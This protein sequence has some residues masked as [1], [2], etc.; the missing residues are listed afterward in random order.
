[1]GIVFYSES[2]AGRW[3]SRLDNSYAVF[4]RAKPLLAPS[5]VAHDTT[6]LACHS[7]WSRM[8]L[9]FAFGSSE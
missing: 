1:M 8:A 6:L 2:P 7:I 3:I 4:F 9:A 5:P